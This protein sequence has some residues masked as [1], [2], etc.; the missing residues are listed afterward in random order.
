LGIFL[1]HLII[2]LV[3]KKFI[4]TH[5]KKVLIAKSEG[6]GGENKTRTSPS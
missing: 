6:G 1:S 5:E 2:F 3:N 4:S